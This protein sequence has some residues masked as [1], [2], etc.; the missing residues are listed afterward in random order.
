[1]L[2]R[3]RQDVE[4]GFPAGNVEKRKREAVNVKEKTKLSV[5]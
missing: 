2:R 1:M 4:E 3:Y 5:F